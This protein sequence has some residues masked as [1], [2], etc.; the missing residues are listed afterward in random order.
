MTNI[1]IGNGIDI[2]FGGLDYTNKSII[3]RAIT[4]L[5]T[6]NYSEDVYPKE[7]EQWIFGLHS[8]I[9]DLLSGKYNHLAVFSEEQELINFKNN[10]DYSVS[11]SEVSFEDYFFI[12]NIYCRINNIS[13]EVRYNWQEYLKR[14]FLDSIFNGGK[15]NLIKDNFPVEIIQFI[16]SFDNI[17]T[18]NYDRNIEIAANKEVLYLHGAFHILSDL[19]N[20]ESFRNKLSDRNFEKHLIN[21]TYLH[22]YSSAITNSSGNLKMFTATQASYTN[23]FLD[24]LVKTM[25]KNPEIIN[26]I[27]NGKKSNNQFIKNLQESL[28]LKTN[29]PDL[30]YSIHYA[31]DKLKLIKD[32]ITFIGLSPNNDSH[33]LKIIK[34]NTKINTI[35][36]YYYN[37]NEVNSIKSF[38]DNKKV[39][40]K[41]VTEFWSKS[42][43]A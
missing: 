31:V 9:N 18:T 33:L 36:F 23:S 21:E 17:F 26:L 13:N 7:T 20:P 2:Q 15:I 29:N 5:Q 41:S 10:Y 22:T 39:E 19:Y 42:A 1:I 43:C 38:L 11:I 24:G 35:E 27:N 6:N 14:L 30:E 34:E 25:D 16:Q 37:M 28:T 40:I 12:N 32:R 4:N 8:I 3:E